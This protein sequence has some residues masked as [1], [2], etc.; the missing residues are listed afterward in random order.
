M[1]LSAT[2]IGYRSSRSESW[3]R[4]H[5]RG[6]NLPFYLIDHCLRVTFEDNQQSNMV[7]LSNKSNPVEEIRELT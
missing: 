5:E 7:H 4:S 1:S 6:K 3:K 2:E